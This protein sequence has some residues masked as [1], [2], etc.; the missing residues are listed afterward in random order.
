MVAELIDDIPMSS[1]FHHRLDTEFAEAVAYAFDTHAFCLQN[2]SPGYV[3]EQ[4]ASPQVDSLVEPVN[5]LLEPV[6]PKERLALASQP[7]EEE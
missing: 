3:V 6:G 4:G 7:I 2:A 5:R 1:H